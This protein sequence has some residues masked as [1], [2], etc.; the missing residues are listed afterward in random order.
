M[1][2]ADVIQPSASTASTGKGIRYIGDYC[3]AYSGAVSVSNTETDLLNFTTG[4]G[5]IV[6]RLQFRY[7]TAG[8]AEIGEDFTFRLYLN[9]EFIM[10]SRGKADTEWFAEQYVKLI[11]PPNT[12]V[13]VTT[14]NVTDS[15][16]RGMAALLTGRVYGAT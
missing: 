5:L 3:Y 13:K 9:Q 10:S 11:L 16:S 2:E 12:L 15:D 4:S 6:G 14:E 8:T 1:T 7:A